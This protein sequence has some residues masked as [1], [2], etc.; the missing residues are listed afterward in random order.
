M[1]RTF[2]IDGRTYRLLEEAG[3]VD[4]EILAAIEN[5]LDW[6]PE[7]EPMPTEEFI[8]RLCKTYGS[9]SF[10][11]PGFDLD[12]YDNPAARKIMREARRMRRER[13]N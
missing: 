7:G 1:T 13:D 5:C 11:K 12:Q 2:D 3:D 6:F 10:D 9:P 8:D 4:E